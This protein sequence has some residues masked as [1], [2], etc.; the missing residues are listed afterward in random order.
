MSLFGTIGATVG[1]YF[2]AA[3]TPGP[4][5]LYVAHTASATSR[6]SALTAAL[7]VASGSTT[8]AGISVL[9][10]GDLMPAQGAVYRLLRLVCGLYLSYLGL[11]ILRDLRTTDPSAPGQVVPAASRVYLR[12]VLTIV[13]NPKAMLFFG[14]LTTTVLPLSVPTA[15]RISAV[16]ALALSAFS[17]YCLVAIAFSS[18]PFQRLYRRIV[19]PID[20]SSGCFFLALGLYLAF[21]P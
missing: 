8:L 15:T 21:A 17:W 10:L 19:F 9:L 5:L 7:G 16:A 6:K 14:A 18:E 12:G 4:N 3:I 11:R 2:A 20:L 13:T 1:I